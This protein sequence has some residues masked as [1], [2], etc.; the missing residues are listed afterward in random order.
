MSLKERRDVIALHRQA[1]TAGGS[2]I[3]FSLVR[4]SGSS[5]RRPGAR[6]LQAAD[7]RTAGTLS[8]GC[9][10]AELLRRSAWMT[11]AGAVLERFSTAFDDTA[12][13]PYGLGCGGQLDLLMEPL[14][15]SEAGALV[16]ALEATLQGEMR[17]IATLLPVRVEPSGHDAGQPLLRVVLDAA[18]DVL[19]ASDALP[20][21][22]V[23][24]LRRL[25]L[26][27]SA[28]AGS[29]EWVDGAMG[30]A[31]VEHLQ[32]VQRM[33]IF[34]AGEDAIP[35]CG[36]ACSM[37]WSVVVIDSR[38]QRATIARFPEAQQV[39]VLA[40]ATSFPVL[41]DDAVV[42][43]THSYEQDRALLAHLLPLAPRYLGLLGARHRSAL[44]L[45]EA[46]LQA[47][48]SLPVAVDRTHAPIGF[49]L[50]GDGPEAVALAIVAEVQ[51]AVNASHPERELSAR[52]VSL[53]EA[54]RLLQYAPLMGS[55]HETCTLYAEPSSEGTV[56]A[57][58]R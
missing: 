56:Q 41:E 44:L 46:S 21:D 19:F 13:I 23:V 18:G 30:P 29:A 55:A 49:E 40:D 47:G 34:G 20:T 32:P 15:T 33:V 9:L 6:L 2:G 16:Q 27:H 10:E 36:M 37:G 28:P 7:G 52:R 39:L 54:E 42:L 17:L 24:D 1:G 58:A 14:A 51:H 43:M 53:A 4:V 22:Q 5:Y 11:R 35:L 45:Q 25:V 3:L 31:F 48:V 8:G 57:V 26:K 12:D 50:G 38:S